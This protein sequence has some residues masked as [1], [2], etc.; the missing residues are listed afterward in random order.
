[1]N[2]HA[3]QKRANCLNVSLS[4]MTVRNALDAV[5]AETVIAVSNFNRH[6]GEA[7]GML[8]K[9]R[10]TAV[11]RAMLAG[12][13]PA[14][15]KRKQRPRQPI[16][17]GGFCRLISLDFPSHDLRQS[18]EFNFAQRAPLRHKHS[19][20]SHHSHSPYAAV[21]IALLRRQA[22]LRFQRSREP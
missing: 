10:T 7:K 2:R 9:Y 16:V 17:V 21:A 13:I 8:G 22:G 12:G 11:L 18:L 15:R 1:M 6:H 4:T 20:C 14:F 5:F 19:E 3:A